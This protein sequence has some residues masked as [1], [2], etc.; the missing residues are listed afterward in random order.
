MG[1]IDVKY[2]LF[3]T[4]SCNILSILKYSQQLKFKIFTFFKIW[5][6]KQKLYF[7]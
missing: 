2:L 1:E 3:W 6:I 4:A 5:K 7:S